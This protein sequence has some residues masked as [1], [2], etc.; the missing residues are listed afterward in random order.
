LSHRRDAASAAA[1]SPHRAHAKADKEPFMS[2]IIEVPG[3]NAPVPSPSMADLFRL[4]SHRAAEASGS[5]WAFMLGVAIVVVWA[6][7]GKLFDYSESW[8]LVINTGTTIVTFLM[9]FVIQN[10]QARDSKELHLKLD[11]LLRAVENARNTVIN[12]ANMSDEEL[13]AM[14]RE[15]EACAEPEN[16][17]VLKPDGTPAGS[18]PA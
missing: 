4:F 12:C 1:P 14:R 10:T 9:V 7:T 13:E 15:L 3:A 17:V 8:Q 6:A 2:G 11:E 18:N 16:G 5:P